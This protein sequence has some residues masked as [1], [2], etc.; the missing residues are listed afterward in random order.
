MQISNDSNLIN[1]IAL[2]FACKKQSSLTGKCRL[3]LLMVIVLKQVGTFVFLTSL[4]SAQAFRTGS[5]L[6][7][8]YMTISIY[9]FFLGV[10]PIKDR[11]RTATV[12]SKLVP[13]ICRIWVMLP[14]SCAW[15]LL[16]TFQLFPIIL[17]VPSVVPRNRFSEPEHNADISLLSNSCLVSPSARVTC[18]ASKKSNDFHWKCTHVSNGVALYMS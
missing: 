10:T 3:P 1:D 16:T 13:S 4:S 12:I 2:F 15:N 14:D 17:T 8:S 11:V 6:K 9:N 18:V 5:L 7:S